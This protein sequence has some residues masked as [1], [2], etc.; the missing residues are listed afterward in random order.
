MLIGSRQ[1]LSQVITDPQLQIRSEKIKRVST[2]KTLGVM[3][4]ECITWDKH[5]DQVTRKVSKGIGLLR[6]SKDLVNKISLDTIY[7]VLVLPHFNYCALVWDNCS[8]TLQN[9]LEKLQNKAG[10]IITGDSYDTPSDIVIKKLGWEI[11]YDR[12]KVQ[13]SSLMKKLVRGENN[14]NV[15]ELFSLS[16]RPCYNLRSN[17]RVLSLPQPNTNAF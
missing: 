14:N 17:N 8:I 3:V 13:L 11:L 6:R 12:R 16:N 7:Q 15:T 1:R 9:K 4:D 10:R 5:I 2:T